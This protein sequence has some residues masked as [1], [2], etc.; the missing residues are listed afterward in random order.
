MCLIRGMFI[1][2]LVFM[3]RPMLT[4][5]L[6]PKQNPSLL[7]NQRYYLKILSIDLMIYLNIFVIKI[8]AKVEKIGKFSFFLNDNF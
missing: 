6:A 5:Y 3:S 1:L 2:E 7:V 4:V 8:H